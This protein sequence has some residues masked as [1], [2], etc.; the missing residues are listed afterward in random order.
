MRYFEIEQPYYGLM[1]ANNEEEAI[2]IYTE[3]IA[4]DDPDSPLID[5]IKEVERDYALVVHARAVSEEGKYETIKT[6]LENF[7]DDKA[8]ILAMDSLLY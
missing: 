7:N 8:A 3:T 2:K 6:L 1:K 4:D 5:E